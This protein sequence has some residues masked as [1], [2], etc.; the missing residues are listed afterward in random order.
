MGLSV[1]AVPG[2]ALFGSSAHE[3]KCAPSFWTIG[4][5][6]STKH[7]PSSSADDPQSPVVDRLTGL[8]DRFRVRA[9]LFHSGVLCGRT[10]FEAIPGRAF[11]HVLR[12]GTMEV[13]H[14]AG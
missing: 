8:L 10:T 3:L 6:P 12:R 2:S 13:R 11:L 7:V 5:M 14:R 1:C 9:A 4:V